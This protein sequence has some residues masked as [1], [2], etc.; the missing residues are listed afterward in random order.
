MDT[1]TL[2]WFQLVSD[3]LTLTDLSEIEHVTQPAISRALTRLEA[4]VGAPLL[5]KNGR[6]LRM[7]A[8][9]AAFKRQVDEMLH[10]LDDGLAAVTQAV[11]PEAGTVALA[12][13]SS[14]ANWLVPLLIRD[15]RTAHPAV[16]FRLHQASE[17]D[18]GALLT[19]GDVDLVI[20]TNRASP[21]GHHWLRLL[22]QPLSVAVA[23]DHPL[24]SLPRV[25]LTALADMD[26]LMLPAT[27]SLTMHT[28]QLCTAAGFDPHVVFEPEDLPT[29]RGFAAAGLGVAVLPTS[30]IGALDGLPTPL[31]YVPIDGPR[32]TRE[33]GMR[34]SREHRLLPSSRLFRDYVT[35]LSTDGRI[36]ATGLSAQAPAG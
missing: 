8:A 19:S 12:F 28:R 36:S 18:A 14:V 13:Q 32:G 35:Q 31:H 34:W 30:G 16:Q 11:D 33:I 27:S 15:F 21:D 17:I 9:G 4:E 5:R 23:W 6:V 1:R 25:E 24:A 22:D 7:T 2:R 10:R 20:G 29:L 26:F 3:G